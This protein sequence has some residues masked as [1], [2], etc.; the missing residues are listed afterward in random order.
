MLGYSIELLVIVILTSKT[1]I[2]DVVL[3]YSSFVPITHAPIYYFNNLY[4]NKVKNRIAEGMDIKFTKFRSSNPLSNAHWSIKLLRII[5]KICRIIYTSFSYY[6]MP[7]IVILINIK[8]MVSDNVYRKWFII[9]E[10][11]IK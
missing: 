3:A 1:K 4:N 11:P 9:D 6:F 2:I 7:F 8:F 10:S 5:Y